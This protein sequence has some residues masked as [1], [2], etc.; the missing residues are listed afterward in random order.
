[1]TA[2]TPAV[3]DDP[4]P[5]NQPA[6]LGFGR[7][8]AQAVRGRFLNRDGRPNSKKYGLGAQRLARLYLA[9]LD[10]RWPAFFAVDAGRAA[11]AQRLLRAR[12]PRARRR[13]AAGHGQTWASTDPFLRAFTF[14]VGVFTTTGTGM[15]HAY[16]ATA[17]W[18]VNLESFVGPD[19]ARRSR[20]G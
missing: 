6:D 13:R 2:P 11:P 15:M 5:L 12:L 18:L 8:V 3:E 14:S 1:M 9:A 20:S 19:H 4:P 16:G 10:A 17:N 7:V